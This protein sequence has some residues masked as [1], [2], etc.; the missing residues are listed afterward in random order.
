MA[1]LHRVIGCRLR[2]ILLTSHG[3][4]TD[5]LQKGMKGPS[6]CLAKLIRRATLIGSVWSALDGQPVEMPL[7]VPPPDASGSEWTQNL[8]IKDQHCTIEM[9]DNGLVAVAAYK[10]GRFDIV[11]MDIQMPQ[12]DG[13]AAT[14]SIHR[15]EQEQHRSPTPIVALTANAFQEEL[16]KSL[17]TGCDAGLTKPIKKTH[18][19]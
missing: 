5:L 14:A 13:Y 16:D 10:A 3:R 17:A 1:P 19:A 18:P 11:L 7:Q 6:A 8:R 4:L 2:G 12:M 15:W 9:V